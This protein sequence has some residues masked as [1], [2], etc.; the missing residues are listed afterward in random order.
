M[1]SGRNVVNTYT[2]AQLSR[3]RGVPPVILTTVAILRTR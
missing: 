1:K 3:S 2:G